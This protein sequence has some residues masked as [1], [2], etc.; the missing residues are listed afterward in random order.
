VENELIDIR[1]D[2]VA[3]H[4]MLSTAYSMQLSM[5]KRS[6]DQKNLSLNVHE[7]YIQMLLFPGV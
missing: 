7:I 5:I 4:L 2:K 6:K 1:I 3:M